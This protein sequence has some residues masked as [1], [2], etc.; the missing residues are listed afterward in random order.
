VCGAELMYHGD[1]L[2]MLLAF[3][4]VTT[5]VAFLL[6]GFD[7]RFAHAQTSPAPSIVTIDVRSR[8]G[9]SPLA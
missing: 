5:S 3:A 1:I 4:L 9:R 6:F 2:V 7:L 8:H